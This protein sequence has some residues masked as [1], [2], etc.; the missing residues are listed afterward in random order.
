[1]SIPLQNTVQR[2]SALGGP[3]KRERLLCAA[4][5][6]FRR[7]GIDAPMSAV[8]E[9]VGAGV[10]SIYRRFGSKHELFAALVARRL[11][12]VAHAAREALTRD[13]DHWTA[14]TE[15]LTSLV[16]RQ[17]ADDVLGD[18]R[19][20]VADHPD[21]VAA[22]AQASDAL[23]QLLAATRAEGRLRPDA[24]TLDL[25]LLFAATRSA[26]QVEPEQWPRMLAL[27]IDAL[28]TRRG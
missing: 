2:W 27:F 15:M 18:V 16:Q 23:E 17:A 13:G 14:L 25:R 1:M 20:I 10:A 11:T 22:A 19:V 6:V 9:E 4:T 12:Q 21:V 5:E 24:T 8:A 7:D 26:K 28:D 3:A